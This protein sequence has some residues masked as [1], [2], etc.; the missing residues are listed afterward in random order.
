M[1]LWIEGFESFGSSPG[2]PT[3]IT[4]KYTTFGSTTNNTLAAGRVGGLSFKVHNDPGNTSAIGTPDF[5]NK[6]TWI[7][8]FGF[9][10]GTRLLDTRIVS[11]YD[12]TSEQF[13]LRMT[14]AGELAVY[15]GTTL[16][17]ASSGAVGLSSNAWCFIELRVTLHGS[18]GAYE[19]RL[20]G[21]NV[22]SASGVRTTGTANNFAQTVR[23]RGAFSSSAVDQ[24]AFDDI[25]IADDTA[26]EVDDF[27][28]SHKVVA[29]YPDGAGASTD[30]A[31]S[32][33]AN[34]AAVDDNPH[35]GDTSYVQSAV[36]QDEDL[37]AYQDVT[38]ND[39]KGVQINGVCRET[40]ATPFSLRLL[41][42]SG[43]TLDTGSDL[44]IGSTSYVTKSRI[45]EEDPDTAAPWTDSAI[46]ASQFGVR[47]VA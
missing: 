43:M 14:G 34:Y 22:L 4:N 46:N 18:A 20:N 6:A 45:L 28:G 26:G 2:T 16:I 8:G 47:V 7:I 42:Q 41:C 12:S 11:L 31:S 33:G 3:G 24:T 21:V 15:R 37:Y 44:A 19:V 5:G 9:R 27:I 40:D 25:Y 23:F 39:I 29:V 17:A 10:P 35:D 1:L 13:T 38:L 30:L 36:D 32:G